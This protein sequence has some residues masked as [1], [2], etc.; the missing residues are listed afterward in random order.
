MK[1][2][3][4]T[5]ATVRLCRLRERPALAE[6]AAAWFHRQWQVPLAAYQTSMAASLASG[7]GAVPA[8]YLAL[9]GDHIVGGLGVIANDFHDRPD[10]TPN[11]CAVFVT[12]AY[13]NRGLAGR[14]LHMAVVDL[15]AAGI[16][17]A[18]LITALEGF[19]ERYGWRYATTV[20]EADGTS[21][22]MYV[23]DTKTALPS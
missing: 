8:W 17:R 9:S 11:V 4:T 22:P 7:A 21:S 14:L 10:L 3:S 12:P 13:R 16:P 1:D 20:T 5:P 18:Y 19:Y 15:A 23:I 2:S 6:P